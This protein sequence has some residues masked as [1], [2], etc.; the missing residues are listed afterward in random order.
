MSLSIAAILTAIL[1]HGEDARE[2]RIRNIERNAWIGRLVGGSSVL[3][4]MFLLIDAHPV[5]A[6]IVSYAD[7]LREI[8]NDLRRAAS[9]EHPTRFEAIE[10]LKIQKR[11]V[12]RDVRKL[13]LDEGASASPELRAEVRRRIELQHRGVNMRRGLAKHMIMGGTILFVGSALILAY[14]PTLHDLVFTSVEDPRLGLDVD[15]VTEFALLRLSE[16]KALLS[17]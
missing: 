14:A 10:M 1:V 4:G 3:T 13:G 8:E 16:Q 9:S 5:D 6:R 15:V 12:L 17:R 7:R 11:N 2:Q